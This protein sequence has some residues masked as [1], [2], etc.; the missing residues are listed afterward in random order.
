MTMSFL[1]SSGPSL[2]PQGGPR[3]GESA[4]LAEALR[5]VVGGEVRF[6]SYTKHLFS[7]DAS[8]YMIEPVG[9]VFPRDS[10]DVSAV[11]TTAAEFGVPVLPRGAGTS[12]VGQTVGHAIVMDSS[13]HMHRI[14]DIDA[15]RSA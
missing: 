5:R 1:R 2:A 4:E 15:G 3:A 11:V 14:I 8:M 7:R 6:D 10:A 13:R 9:V 12:L